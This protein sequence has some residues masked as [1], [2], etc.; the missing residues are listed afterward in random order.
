[1]KRNS[2]GFLILS[3]VAFCFGITT[4]VRGHVRWRGVAEITG[5]QAIILGVAC[6]GFSIALFISTKWK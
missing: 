3:L 6:I 1:M 4:I 5:T 2:A